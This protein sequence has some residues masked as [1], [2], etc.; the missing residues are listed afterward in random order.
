[1]YD[2]DAFATRLR[3]FREQKGCTQLQLAEK[4][5]IALQT[6]QHYEWGWNYPSTL[7]LKYLC[8]ALEISSNDLIGL[9]TATICLPKELLP[10]DTF[11]ERL[12]YFRNLRNLSQNQL[13]KLSGVSL[14][15]IKG[16]ENYRS[17]PNVVMLEYLCGALDAS[18]EDLLGF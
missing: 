16:Y 3:I 13:V 5:G 9:G 2:L 15:Q 1:M 4:A 17:N 12:K 10:I 8:K 18:G 11:A 14:S 7:L 6:I